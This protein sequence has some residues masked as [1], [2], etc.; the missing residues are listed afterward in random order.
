MSFVPDSFDVP[1]RLETPQ[2]VIRK[3]TFADA[4]LDYEAVSSSL[5]IIRATR[6]GLYGNEEQNLSL[7]ENQISLGWHQ[8]EFEYRTSF[9]YTI[10]TPDG[11]ECIGCIYIYP[12]GYYAEI[13][14]GADADVSFWVS[15]KAYDQGLYPVVYGVLDQWL[16]DVWPFKN[17]AYTNKFPPQL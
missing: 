15:Q 14:A 4:A 9:A 17:I 8:R 7:T 1:E 2:F 5:D 6:G 12:P 10:T 13:P 3:L 11:K 16:K